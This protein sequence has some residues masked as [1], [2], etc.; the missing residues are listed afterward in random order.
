M[1]S[2]VYLF[3]RFTPEALLFEALLI[4]ILLSG[5][6]AFW[7]LRKRRFGVVENELPAGPVRVYLNEL[8]LNAEQLR[9]QLFGLMAAHDTHSSDLGK[10]IAAALQGGGSLG[11]TG[12]T[13]AVAAGPPLSVNDPELAK[14][15]PALEA[16]M[17]EQAKAMETII[18]EKTRIEKELVEAKAAAAK[19]ASAPVP[20][21]EAAAP[22]AAVGGES[23]AQVEDLSKKVKELEGKLAEYNVIEDDLANLKRLQ[24]ENTQLKK[25]LAE[26]GGSI[27]QLAAAAPAVAAASAATESA[28]TA[29]APA[30]A[31]PAA[32]ASAAAPD[33]ADPAFDSL[34]AQVEESLAAPSGATAAPAS[35][36]GSQ[37]ASA[38]TADAAP[39]S[40]GSTDAA[41]VAD[42]ATPA[43]AEPSEA[44]LVA[45]F[46]KMLK[47]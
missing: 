22:G 40:A 8:I 19:S 45:E 44:D 21:G 15:L 16:K 30:V 17:A 39:A 32:V 2:W 43:A 6:T 20:N 26:K 23:A 42:A 24:Q 12:P 38:P 18:I 34:A 10:S 5:Y 47:G 41:P 27:E 25:L 11:A 33:A 29:P 28:P 46:E 9:A 13:G 3:S 4:F 36:G 1:D 35:A 14:K 37:A 31:Q 7:V